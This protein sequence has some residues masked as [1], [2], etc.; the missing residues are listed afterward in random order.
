[1]HCGVPV[2]GTYCTYSQRDG[3]AIWLGQLVI[4]S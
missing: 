3:Q 1:M 4:L 2:S